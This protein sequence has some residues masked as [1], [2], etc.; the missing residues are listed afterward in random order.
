MGVGARQ[1]RYDPKKKKRN[2]KLGKNPVKPGNR[3][4]VANEKHGSRIKVDDDHRFTL[5]RSNS[6]F[7][8]HLIMPSKTQ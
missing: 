3:I 8:L 4:L 7:E 1:S 6:K 5:T 2:K